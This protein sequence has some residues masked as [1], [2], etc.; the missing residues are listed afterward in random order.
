[1]LYLSELVKLKWVIDTIYDS[2]III[3]SLY[4]IAQ[5]FMVQ[6]QNTVGPNNLAADPFILMNKLPRILANFNETEES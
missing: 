3:S 1:M 4:N 5:V 6:K 2:I